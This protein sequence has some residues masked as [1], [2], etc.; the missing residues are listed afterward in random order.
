MRPLPPATSPVRKASASEPE[1][2][3]LPNPLRD[4]TRPVPGQT[5]QPGK[6][7]AEREIKTVAV[8]P[9]AAAPL[10]VA[11]KPAPDKKTFGKG[12]HSGTPFDPIKENGPIFVDWPKPKAALLFTGRQEGHLEPCGCAGFDRMKGGVARRYTFIK[13]LGEQGWPLA[14]LDVGALGKGFGKQAELKFHNTVDAYKKM[15]YAVIG[16][17][18][19]DL[20]LPAGELVTETAGSPQQKSPFVCANAAPIAFGAEII[21][22]YRVI[23]LGG[24]RIGVTA[25][26]GKQFQQQV[27]NTE[28]VMEDPQK[29]LAEVVPELKRRA[30]FLVL[31][32]Y[33]NRAESIALGQQ[34][35]DFK[36]VA[37]ADGGDDPPAQPAKIDGPGALLL[38]VGR[39]GSNAIVIGLYDDPN[40]PW[41]YQ[42][43]PLDSR[44]ANAPEMVQV[45]ENYQDQ[46]KTLGWSN[47]APK[48]V[49][50][51]QEESNGRFVGSAKCEACHE[52]SNRVWKRG[53]HAKAYVTL[54]EAKPPRNYDPECVSCHVVG[55]NGPGY[56]PYRNGFDTP[57]KTPQLLHVGCEAC[58][59]PG[60][61]H[62]AAED[63]SDEALKEKLRKAM[64]LT[65]A[66]AKKHFC[67]TCHDGDNSPDFEFDAYWPQI[68]HYEKE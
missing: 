53:G 23:E 2:A 33:A 45:M 12:K 31:L 27:Q 3:P 25:I 15:G 13:Q 6:P 55:W 42:R 68:E 63:G 19:S 5:L 38:E 57:E 9:G 24:M 29:K 35:P 64:I 37:T 30:S 67:L 1:A 11:A 41:R 28:I 59:G 20:R 7:L 21:E 43:V 66:D 60:E 54:E 61:K 62:V 16:L 4:G 47:L 56:F 52:E 51:P 48:P 39:K 34:F 58:H 32:A 36:I 17:G 49:A 50:H 44:F 26:L 46:L 18:L 14:A 65:K 40:R 22:P 8:P 10:L